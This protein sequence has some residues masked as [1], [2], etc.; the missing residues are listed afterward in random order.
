MVPFL[1]TLQQI[2]STIHSIYT[3]PMGVWVYPVIYLLVAIEG[4]MVI[5]LGASAASTGALNPIFLFLTA[6][7]GNLSAD[8][9]WYSLGY[10]GRVNWIL[11]RRKIFGVR[12][13]NMDPIVHGMQKH[14]VKILFMA[15]ISNG[16]IVPALIAAGYARVPLKRWLPFVAFG[17]TLVTGTLILISYYAFANMM[18]V[19]KGFEYFGLGVSILLILVVFFIARNT[20]TKKTEIM[21]E[22]L[23]KNEQVDA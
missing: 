18:Q 1:E 15:K 13:P 10:F 4:P 14:A 2:W 16:M 23:D 8:A 9:V 20:L 5:L 22:N 21:E 12:L 7:A 19:T 17:E 6:A 3:H 11:R